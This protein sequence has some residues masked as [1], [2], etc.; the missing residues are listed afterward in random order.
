MTVETR[1]DTGGVRILTLNRPPA[2]A[3]DRQLLDELGAACEAAAADENVRA[4]VLTGSGKFFCGGLD[5]KRISAEG[6]AGD[7]EFGLGCDDGL[8]ALWTLPKPTIAMINGHAVAGGAILALA[9]DL[10]V[11]GSGDAKI[12]LN[13]VAIGLAFPTGAWEIARAALTQQQV[14]RVILE[15]RLHAPEIA[16]ELGL[17]DEV[18]EPDRLEETCLDHART[19]G[20]YP[21]QAY[22]HS[23]R[24]LQHA[25][26][27]R[28]HGE[29][30]SQRRA[31]AD[32]WTSPETIQ[33][34]R[35]RLA[36]IGRRSS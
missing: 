7:L 30:V 20:G 4:V 19:L 17:V 16:R 11:A 8:F 28:V 27:D 18:V 21:A 36:E 22:A 24:T 32:I 26:I 14:R 10:R 6:G 1:D 23:K 15:A 12:G 5:L 29:L 35:N 33:T 34:L 31:L 2:H 25:A 13:E 9:C 3:I